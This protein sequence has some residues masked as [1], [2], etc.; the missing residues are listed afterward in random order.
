MSSLS[1]EKDVHLMGQPCPVHA[2][3]VKTSEFSI[4]IHCLPDKFQM[5]T[6]L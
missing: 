6:S 3:K 2:L 4:T 1:G 5:G